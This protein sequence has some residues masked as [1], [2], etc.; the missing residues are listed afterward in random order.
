M[1]AWIALYFLLVVSTLALL[2]LPAVRHWAWARLSV[3]RTRSTQAAT[4]A[5]N[6]GRASADQVS[7]SVGFHTGSLARWVR[8]HAWW[9]GAGA[10][11]VIGLPLLALSLRGWQ[12][13]GG[14]DH[15]NA[16]EVNEQIEALLQ[17]EQLVPP[18]PLPPEMFSTQ[19]VEM[20][21][22]M[23]RTAS[24]E[25]NLL[26]EVYRQRLLVVFKI[27]KEQYG[28]DLVLLEGYRSPERQ[29]RLAAMGGHV[30]KAG[31]FRSYHQYGLAADCA[32]LRQGK[33]VISERDPW[34]MR[35]Y[36]LY[37]Q[38]AQSVGLT[39]GGSWRSIKDYG[40]TELRRPG[41]LGK[42]APQQGGDN[43]APSDFSGD[44]VTEH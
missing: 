11:L 5:A 12:D 8:Q 1:L 14:F 39:W 2:F 44:F 22:P 34:A 23:I 37:G 29:E 18:P 35:G 33:V 30:T 10:A 3:I 26:D 6:R 20:V 4:V 19:E 42:A 7:D 32:F 40:H 24:R 43:T 28:Y 36:E 17:G 16:R 21:R 27:M 25:W 13:L 9:T 15:R 41:V 31:A 38:V